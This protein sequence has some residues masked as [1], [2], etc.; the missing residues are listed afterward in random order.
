[1]R[2]CTGAGEGNIG[3]AVH[4]FYL[5]VS[6]CAPRSIMA[7]V[8]AWG[9]GRCQLKDGVGIVSVGPNLLSL[10]YGFPLQSFSLLNSIPCCA[11]HRVEW[12]LLVA[13][14]QLIGCRPCNHCQGLQNL[15]LD[16]PWPHSYC[17]SEALASFLV[18]ESFLNARSWSWRTEFAMAVK[19]MYDSTPNK[20]QWLEK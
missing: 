13:L 4:A 12:M 19:K 16:Q 2:A 15:L 1:M 6:D 10:W 20:R 9:L 18:G 7:Q 17:F 11:K 8:S 5:T 14:K 3:S